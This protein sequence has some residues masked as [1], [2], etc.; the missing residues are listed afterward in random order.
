MLPSN[1][2]RHS[3]VRQSF[4]LQKANLR[5]APVNRVTLHG[6]K[7]ELLLGQLRRRNN[8]LDRKRESAFRGIATEAN[9]KPS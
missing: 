1:S 4:N 6:K 3:R 5:W 7:H 2:A 9:V 8:F